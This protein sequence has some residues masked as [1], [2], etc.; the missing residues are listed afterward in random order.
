M[1]ATA[2]FDATYKLWIVCVT[3]TTAS[4]SALRGSLQGGF[5]AR[6][7]VSLD[8]IVPPNDPIRVRRPPVL[9]STLKAAATPRATPLPARAPVILPLVLQPTRTDE[10]S[11]G[12]CSKL[13]FIAMKRPLLSIFLAA[14]MSASSKAALKIFALTLTVT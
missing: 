8:A 10:P 12:G 5:G 9:P 7:I 6:S 3:L 1:V 14:A 2:I 13:A 4:M 11:G